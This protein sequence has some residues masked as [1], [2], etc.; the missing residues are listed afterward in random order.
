M[1]VI[2]Y[3]LRIGCSWRFLSRDLLSASLD[4]VQNLSQAPA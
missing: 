4:R 1:N 2:P 3:L